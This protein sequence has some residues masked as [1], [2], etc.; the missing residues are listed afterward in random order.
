LTRKTTRSDLESELIA[1]ASN[2]SWTWD[3][4]TQHLFSQFPE[5]TKNLHP[6]QR[7]TAFTD[8]DYDRYLDDESFIAQAKAAVE[9][10]PVPDRLPN[11]EIAYFSPEFGITETLPQYSGGLGVL[12]GDHLKASSDLEL[13]LVAVGLFYRDGFF[14][15]SIHD[16][17]QR[18]HY[19]RHDPRSLGLEQMGVIV[20]IVMDDRVVKARVW[21]ADVGRTKLYL[22]DT[23]LDLNDEEG[24]RV[25]DRLYGGDREHRIRQELLMGVG[26][27][28]AIRQ[29]GYEP[30]VYHL[31]EGHA[32]FLALELI[33]EEINKGLT[34]DEAVDAVRPRIVF[35]THTP[36]P[37][38]IDRFPVDLMDRYLGVWAERYGVSI[39]ELCKLAHMPGEDDTFNMAAFC[40]N[41]SSR[42]NG[43]AKLHGSVSRE[44]FAGVR[45]GSEIT[46][47]TN[48]VHVET[49]VNNPLQAVFEE[50]MGPRWGSGVHESW[51]AVDS[52]D[53]QQIRSVR[54]AGR[55]FLIDEVSR[56]VGPNH[57]LDPNVLTIGFARRFATYKRADLLLRDIGRLT[58]TL[59]DDEHPVQ[60]VFAGKAHPADDP[61]KG[62]LH[63]VVTFANSVEANGRF[64]FIPD[65]EM[66]VARAMYA[67]CD[68][69]LNNP[70]RPNEACGTSGEKAAL[71]G[72]LNFS[73]L[74]GWW[75]ECYDGDNGWKIE[76]SDVEN[77]DVR[78]EEEAASLHQILDDEIVPLFYGGEDAPSSGW[79]E[80]V[81]HNWKSL[82]PF[83]SAARMVHEYDTRLYRPDGNS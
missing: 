76:T 9:R 62:V 10:I 82:G 75:D 22:L 50:A 48:G 6:R 45:G 23:D 41:V 80:K 40:L 83:V 59:A 36:V 64:I 25:S 8:A 21:R 51:T 74:D 19:E 14:H 53:D 67:G 63:R 17:Q 69:W 4:R 1:V 24:R 31:N 47:V 43:V 78:D 46:S 7:V 37:A 3:R 57:R 5:A 33:G 32:G 11:A 60:F 65:Y 42:A 77:P 28:R 30:S 18:E 56:R 81:R 20:D 61:G 68:V 55:Q 79:L 71:N 15:Q 73:V 12:A 72:G 49:W 16:D 27:V 35:T 66:S 52:I 2:Y 13:P 34:L 26:G 29:L 39:D 44:M 54:H 70:I 38:G 58:S